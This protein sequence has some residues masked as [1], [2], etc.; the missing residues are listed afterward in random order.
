MACRLTSILLGPAGSGKTELYKQLAL[1]IG[2]D[3]L[4]LYTAHL[5]AEEIK[6]L[7]FRSENSSKTY[8]V[9]CNEEIYDAVIGATKG[10]PLVIFLD[11]LNRASDVDC[12][13]ALFSM[14]SKRG[15]PGL[16]FPENVFIVA[17]GNPPTGNFAVAEMSDDAYIR[18]LVWLGCKVDVSTYLKYAQGKQ[19]FTIKESMSMEPPERLPIHDKVVDYIKANPAE[20]FDPAMADKGK[21]HPNPASWDRI[22]DVLKVLEREE[23]VSPFTAKTIIAGLIG[24]TLAVKFWEFYSDGELYISPEEILKDRWSKVEKRLAKIQKAGRHD[25]SSNLVTSVC[26][27]LRSDMPVLLDKQVT[28]LVKFFVFLDEDQQALARHTL[29]S[30]KEDSDHSEFGP[31]IEDLML[32]LQ[33][34]EE[35]VEILNKLMHLNT[36]G[37][38]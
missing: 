9:L 20:L 23:K 10:K 15:V 36:G 14:I 13:N 4:H 22:S 12:L 3:M 24:N 26:M 33:G 27:Y 2:A 19:S 17:A 29:K 18:R 6:G 21:P 7:F 34:H 16:D 38:R 28:N 5:G 35:F 37:G 11:E 31:Y 8:S 1:S 30:D 25:I 32:R